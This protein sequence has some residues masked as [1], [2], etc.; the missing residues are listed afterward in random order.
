[1]NSAYYLNFK[2][3]EALEDASAGKLQLLTGIRND[4]STNQETG[5][6]THTCPLAGTY[7]GVVRMANIETMKHIT[8]TVTL[9]I[10]E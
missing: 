8:L 1:M 6:V 3:G 4:N 2:Y 5:E 9:T 10:T 7:A